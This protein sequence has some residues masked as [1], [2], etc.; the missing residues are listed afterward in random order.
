VRPAGLVILAIGAIW[1]A[2]GAA[3]DPA[4]ARAFVEVSAAQP[5]YFV[6]EPVEVVLLVGFDAAWFRSNAIQ[7]SRVELDVPLEVA[8]PWMRELPGVV[9]VPDEPQRPGS[10]RKMTFALNGEKTDATVVADRVANGTTFTV[11]RV[12]KR[13]LASSAGTL[14]IAAPTLR[15]AYAT[16]F[17]DDLV[18][19]RVPIDRKDAIVTGRELSLPILALPDVGRPAQFGGAVGRFSISAT[20][21]RAEVDAGES[22]KLALTIEGFGNLDSFDAPRLDPIQGLHVY[23]TIEARIGARRTVIYD[24]AFRDARLR[25][26]PPIALVYFDPTPPAQYRTAWSAPIPVKV[27][28]APASAPVKAPAPTAHALVPGVSDIFGLRAS[29]AARADRAYATGRYEEALALFEAALGDPDAPAGIILFDLGSS[30]WR[31]GRHAEALRFWRR[32]EL[33]LPRDPQVAF[34]VRFAERQLEVDPPASSPLDLLGKLTRTERLATG[35]AVTAGAIV[36]MILARRRR[37]AVGLLAL[38]AVLGLALAVHALGW[39]AGAPRG[40]VLGRDIGLRAEPHRES[41]TALRLRA[42]ETVRV[43]ER[44][45]RWSRVSHPRGSG[46][47]ESAGIGVVD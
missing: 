18:N 5:S 2:S 13:V 31:L 17:E 3:Q 15:F 45:D 8:A 25:A 1:P 29:T 35:A 24:V 38:A 10:S 21:D 28:A 11:L 20:L 23:G 36:A 26:I 47:T 40:I 6:Q 42:G 4:A 19:G 46:W 9:V 43:H 32:A 16:R 41:S 39:L 44:S 14:A 12:T 37:I 7:T 34:N 22:L 33:R 27:R 30:A